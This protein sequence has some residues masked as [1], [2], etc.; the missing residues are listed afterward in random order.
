MKTKFTYTIDNQSITTRLALTTIPGNKKQQK[1]TISKAPSLFLGKV[2][3]SDGRVKQTTWRRQQK[4][5]NH[6]N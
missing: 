3:R 2:S 1:T 6:N 5:T 4:T